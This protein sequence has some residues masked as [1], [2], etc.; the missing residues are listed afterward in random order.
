MK[1]VVTTVILILVVITMWLATSV[2]FKNMQKQN[3][4]CSMVS[5][6]PDYTTKR[7]EA[8]KERLLKQ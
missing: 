6:H 1:R 5:F 8:C 7:R 3:V 2:D 4:D